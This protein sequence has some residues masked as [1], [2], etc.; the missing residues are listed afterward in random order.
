M[1]VSSTKAR[2]EPLVD[3]R[4]DH[5]TRTVPSTMRVHGSWALPMVHGL[6]AIIY[7]YVFDMRVFGRCFVKGTRA[8]AI[9]VCTLCSLLYTAAVFRDLPSS[10]ILLLLCLT[11]APE[12]LKPSN[13]E[14]K[15]SIDSM[16][17]TKSG[18]V[19]RLN[20]LVRLG[21]AHGSGSTGMIRNA[22]IVPSIR[23]R[24]AL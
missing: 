7:Q 14:S 10:L 21:Y 20:V 1:N 23:L 2:A 15:L 8:W 12:P 9:F 18:L 6:H 17:S 19:L 4:S 5:R 11:P 22:L 13:P 16:Y 24:I 3:Q